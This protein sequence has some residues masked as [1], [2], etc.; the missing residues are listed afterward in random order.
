MNLPNNTTK[1]ATHQVGHHKPK[2]QTWV[3]V[4]SI[5]AIVISLASAGFTAFVYSNTPLQIH[6]YVQSHKDELK[7]S[8]GR[9]GVSGRNGTNTYSPTSCSSYDYGYGYTSTNCR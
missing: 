4:L 9:D 6:N 2:R 5:V 3:I 7:G 1:S 8:D